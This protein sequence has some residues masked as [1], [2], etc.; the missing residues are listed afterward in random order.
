MILK[1]I[2]F[3]VLLTASSVLLAAQQDGQSTIAAIK[4]EGLRS[5]EA[6]AIF[7]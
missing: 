5:T 3:A 6:A 2:G 7:R 1:R 4:A